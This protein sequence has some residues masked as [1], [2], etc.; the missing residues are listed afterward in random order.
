MEALR[1]THTVI[2]LGIQAP[3][4]KT[5]PV[6]VELDD[7]EHPK[8]TVSVAKFARYLQ[9]EGVYSYD[10][11]RKA[12]IAIGKLRDFYLCERGG[13]MLTPD[14]MKSLLEDFLFAIDH[15]TILN[16]RPASNHDYLQ[17]RS[18]VFEYVKFLLDNPSVDWP[19]H[20]LR[21]IAACRDA[22]QNATHAEKSLLFHTKKR[23]RKKARGRKR[24]V[25]G[26]RHYKPFPPDLVVPLIEHTKNIRDKLLFS[27][28]AFGGRRLS[29]MLHLFVGDV[30]ARG[31]SVGVV[32]RHPSQSPM[33]WTSATGATVKGSRVEYLRNMFQLL[34]RTEHGAQPSAAGW[35][36][37]KF[38]DEARM[39]SEVYFIRE[40]E[41]YLLTLHRAYLH[42]VRSKVPRRPHPYYFV[43]LD[44]EPLTIRAVEKQF[45]L[46]CRRLEKKY[47]VSLEGYGP[48]S[49]RHYYGFY[50]A[51]V[52][53]ADLLLIQKWMGHAQPSSTAVYAHISPETAAKAL[54]D[55][56]I[57][58][59]L[60]GRVSITP[61]E[62]EAI[63]QS[64]AGQSIEPIPEAWRLDSTRFG[65]LDTRNLQ[66]PLR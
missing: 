34:P 59:K 64:F 10:K 52:L 33:K 30:E 7:P 24:I 6:L 27:L 17:T 1:R 53:R 42:E 9:R 35:K 50:C 43:A 12:V 61:E 66:R 14:G 45:S 23:G 47:G 26:L 54:A 20:E 16:W 37:M 31:L 40:V 62:R 38:D 32:L 11:L 49:L 55:A 36:G 51:D 39:S 63:A 21:F 29:E 58:A 65:M 2:H 46:A 28:M 18:A 25:T 41:S 56:Q 4:A 57:Q 8:I 48:H 5:L 13:E 3:D 19:T 60:D 22:W 44:G 15:G